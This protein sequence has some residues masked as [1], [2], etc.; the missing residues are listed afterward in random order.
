M[1]RAGHAGRQSAM[2]FSPNGYVYDVSIGR[3][4]MTR[5]GSILSNKSCVLRQESWLSRK[6]YHGGRKHGTA[7]RKEISLLHAGKTRG[8]REGGCDILSLRN[9]R[10]HEV[11]T[12]ISEEVGEGGRGH[13]SCVAEVGE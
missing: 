10:L 11:Y 6:D 5:L 1:I 7:Y 3:T 8:K 13:R 2:L 9:E 4:L 12:C